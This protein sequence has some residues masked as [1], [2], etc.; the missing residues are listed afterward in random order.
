MS[1]KILVLTLFIGSFWI[2]LQAEQVIS[3]GACP[4][5]PLKNLSVGVFG[6][7][8]SQGQTNDSKQIWMDSLMPDGISLQIKTCGIGGMGFSSNT[9]KNVPWQIQ[10]AD[11]FDVYIFWCSTNDTWAGQIGEIGTSDSTTQSGGLLKSVE[12]IRKRNNAAIILLFTSL[13]YFSKEEGNLPTGQLANYVEAQKQFCEAYKIP[14]LDL[15]FT[16]GFTT[17]N[18]KAYYLPD[19]LHLTNAGYCFVATQQAHFLKE[20][21]RNIIQK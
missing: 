8:I 18:Y 6:G 21:L 20:A 2:C 11:T 7:S 14:Y 9:V 3:T 13:P 15:F 1:K 5:N 10:N 16:C 12:I 4:A 19:N 17:D